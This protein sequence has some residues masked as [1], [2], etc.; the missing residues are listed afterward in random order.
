MKRE[1]REFIEQEEAVSAAKSKAAK[2]A[3]RAKSTARMAVWIEKSIAN[4]EA[5]G[6]PNAATAQRRFWHEAGYIKGPCPTGCRRHAKE[7]K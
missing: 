6:N 1:T 7:A 5:N 4:L 2:K 3:K